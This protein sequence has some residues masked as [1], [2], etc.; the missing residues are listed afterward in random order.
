MI[1]KILSRPDEF[2]T[3]ARILGKAAENDGRHCV[4]KNESFQKLGARDVW[5]SETGTHVAF[6]VLREKNIRVSNAPVFT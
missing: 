5:K 2:G 1:A 4:R 6:F 3:A